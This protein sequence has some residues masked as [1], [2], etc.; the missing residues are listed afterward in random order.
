MFLIH[1]IHIPL[2]YGKHNKQQYEN[3]YKTFNISFYIIR[4]L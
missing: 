3:S 2:R 4:D 1:K